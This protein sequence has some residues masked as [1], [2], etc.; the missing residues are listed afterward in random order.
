MLKYMVQRE[1]LVPAYSAAPYPRKKFLAPHRLYGS[2]GRRSGNEDSSL[3]SADTAAVP[4][5]KYRPQTVATGPS[6]EKARNRVI[7]PSIVTSEDRA[8]AEAVRTK[9]TR[10]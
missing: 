2:V 10:V 5:G 1:D 4:R 8:R 7:R 9:E 6:H 3:S